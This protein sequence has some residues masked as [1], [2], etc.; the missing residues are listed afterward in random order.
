MTSPS[1]KLNLLMAVP[2]LQSGS[3]ALI[4]EHRDSVRFLLDSGAFTAWKLNK[5]ITLDYYC[6]FIDGLPFRPWRYFA[7]DVIGDA[8]ATRRNYD[9]LLAR[10][11]SP[12]PIFTR[13][14][15][16]EALRYYLDTSDVV[17][18]GGLASNI[19][20]PQAYLKHIWPQVPRERVHVLGFTQMNWIK[21]FRPYSCDSSSWEGGARYGTFP[22]Y[23]GHGRIKV[24]GRADFAARPDRAYMARIDAMGFDPFALRD[25][26]NWRGGNSTTRYIGAMSNIQMSLDTGRHLGTKLFLACTTE[27]AVRLLLDCFDRIAAG[28]WLASAAG[29]GL[30]R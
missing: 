24:L 25:P 8:A 26:D 14:E 5:E 13:G 10:G 20:K 18:L 7:L 23:M 9:T 12:V 21:H 22:L 4:G 11:F 15:H 16:P 27:T 28:R 2:Y 29:K 6:K 30:R 19:Q 3:M 17:G 1:P